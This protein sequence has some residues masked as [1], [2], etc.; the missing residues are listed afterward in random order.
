M[1]KMVQHIKLLSKGRKKPQ[2]WVLWTS[3]MVMGGY[4]SSNSIMLYQRHAERR[5]VAEINE[6]GR[7]EATAKEVQV[8]VENICHSFEQ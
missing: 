8:S 5:E 2:R 7:K 1:L 3:N 6:E 4:T